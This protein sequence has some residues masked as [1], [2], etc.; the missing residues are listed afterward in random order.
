MLLAIASLVV[1]SAG[2]TSAVLY[3]QDKLPF[4]SASISDTAK[5][6]LGEST[7]TVSQELETSKQE[8]REAKAEAEKLR[9][10]LE[11]I[12]Q[13]QPKQTVIVREV[14]KPVEEPTKVNAE[15]KLS[16][17]PDPEVKTELCKSKTQQTKTSLIN[18]LI[19]RR[20]QANPSGTVAPNQLEYIYNAADELY[21]NY[22]N[23]C[24]S[25]GE[26]YWAREIL[27]DKVLRI[28]KQYSLAEKLCKS[29]NDIKAEIEARKKYCAGEIP[30]ACPE[31]EK[32]E[33]AW[34]EYHEAKRIYEG[35]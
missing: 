25:G 8:A 28:C 12:K 14:I 3:G 18:N 19:E 22:L 6:E 23:E 16:Y 34:N 7:T 29:T 35:Y 30:N 2:A 21:T 9:E 32:L 5:E 33:S 10:E 20:E 11:Q 26:L 31:A 4:L 13:T 24:L 17:I 15:P 1:V 27:H